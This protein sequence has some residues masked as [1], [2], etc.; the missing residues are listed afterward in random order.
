MNQDRTTPS[1]PL[2][3]VISWVDRPEILEPLL[4]EWQ[5]LAFLTQADIYLTPAWFSIWWSHFGAGRGFACLV[6]R[7]GE[8]LVGILPFCIETFWLGPMRMRVARLAGTDPHC[9]IFT[10]PIERDVAPKILREACRYLLGPGGCDT[11]SLKPVSERADFLPLLMQI[12]GSSAD[13]TVTDLPLGSHVIFDLPDSF[14]TY[15]RTRLSKKRRA[16]F[17]QNLKGLESSFATEAHLLVPNAREFDAFVALHNAQ[18]QAV[19]KGGHFADWP[20]S[21]AFFRALTTVSLPGF[22]IQFDSL[23]GSRGPLA[24]QFSLICG[25]T[26]HW[27]LP[28]RSLDQNA[29]RLSIGQVGLVLMIKGLIETGVRRIEGGRGEY[30]YKLSLGGE[31]VPVHRLLISR[32]T[33]ISK[34]R[35]RLLMSYVDLLNLFYYRVWFKKLAPRLRRLTGGKPRPLWRIWIRTRI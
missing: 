9:M 10:L 24:T 16:H 3:I 34:V 22:G 15:L 29:E 19:G 1:Y 28:A 25:Q 8:A 7:H 21:A 20:N 5:R 14:D 11:I 2:D 17:R 12:Q 27:R 23:E 13:L 4:A 35:L 33:S 31:N 18:W 32:A 6:A 30:D 26:A